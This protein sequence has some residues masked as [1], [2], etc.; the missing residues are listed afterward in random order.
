MARPR[1]LGLPD[2]ARAIGALLEDGAE[3]TSA[4]VAGRLGVSRRTVDATVARGASGATFAAYRAR[5]PAAGAVSAI[6]AMAPSDRWDPLGMQVT[7]VLLPRRTADL[8]AD[9][10]R[11]A[12]TS[13]PSLAGRLIERALEAGAAEAGRAPRGGRGGAA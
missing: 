12:H 13:V 9:R 7:R 3:P 5:F 10:A 11:Y 2:V 8:L 6:G 4:L 1:S